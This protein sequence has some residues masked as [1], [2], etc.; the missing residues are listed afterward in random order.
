MGRH[1]IALPSTEQIVRSSMCI[2]M[3]LHA[4]NNLPSSRVAWTETTQNISDT[5]QT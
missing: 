3:Q 5:I 2:M 4:N 1:T